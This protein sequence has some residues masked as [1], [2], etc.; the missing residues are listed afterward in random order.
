MKVAKNGNKNGL[1]LLGAGGVVALGLGATYL[2]MNQK[3]ETYKNYLIILFSQVSRL[4]RP[5]VVKI[6]KELRKELF[7]VFSNFSMVSM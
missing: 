7:S 5:I 4:D 2:F 3:K 6:L 1:L